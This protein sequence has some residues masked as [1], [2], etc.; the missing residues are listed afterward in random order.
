[1]SSS[2]TYYGTGKKKGAV[3]RVYLTLGSGKVVINEKSLEDYFARDTN[4]MV[5]HQPFQLLDLSKD[6]DVTVMVKGGGCSGQAVAIRHGITKA[7][8][9]YDEANP[10]QLNG[11]SST[12]EGGEGGEGGES[13]E[14]G[15]LSVSSSLISVRSSLKKAGYITRDSRIKER[16][17]V[18][19]KKARKRPQFSKR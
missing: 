2:Q 11:A 8:L 15:Q 14:S 12:E 9:S 3:A 18:G 17:K 16:K 10:I 13:G 4:A 1:M 6:F 19:L 7:L 5:V